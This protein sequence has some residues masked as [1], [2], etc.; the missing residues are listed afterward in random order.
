M[1]DAKDPY[2]IEP[3]KSG[4]GAAPAER[5]AG[6]PPADRPP[7]GK[8]HMDAPRL[9][10][11]FEEDADF[12]RDPELERVITG[13]TGKEERRRAPDDERPEF[14]RPIGGEAMHWAIAGGILLLAA[15][16]AAGVNAPDKTFLRIALALY[17]TLL[18]AGTGVV[19]VFVAALLLRSRVGSPELAAARMFTAV[20]AFMLV[21]NLKINIFGEGWGHLV[22][23]ELVLATLAYVAIVAVTFRL[24]KWLPLAYVIGTHF[25]LWLVVQVGM[26]LSSAVGRAPARP[27]ARPPAQVERPATAPRT[28]PPPAPVEPPPAGP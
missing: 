19:A 10:D 27:E 14:G 4:E 24:F 18:H 21:W 1:N 9:L 16:V 11:D 6:E 15:L 13:K 22:I 26:E 20:A 28:S 25:V 5:P 2:E 3:E 12:D 23:E 7:P 17:M 8:A